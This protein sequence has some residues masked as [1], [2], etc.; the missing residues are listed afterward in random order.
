MSIEEE[1]KVRRY[2]LA[3]GNKGPIHVGMQDFKCGLLGEKKMQGGTF[4][5]GHDE[6]PEI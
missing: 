3:K 1:A 4:D 5:S 6:Q 2:A